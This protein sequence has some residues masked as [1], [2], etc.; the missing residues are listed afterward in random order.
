[1]DVCS[2]ELICSHLLIVPQ[3]NDNHLAYLSQQP[4]LFEWRDLK[5]RVLQ[6]Q[7]SETLNGDTF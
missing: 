6:Y 4:R 1:M 7:S 3:E 5:L 2:C